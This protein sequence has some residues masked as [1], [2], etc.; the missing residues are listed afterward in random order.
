MQALAILVVALLFGGMF[1][2]S[3]GF[4]AFVF[5]ALPAALA[6]PTLRRAF[7]HFYLFVI[8]TAAVAAVLMLSLDKESALYLAIIAITT[9][10]ARQFLMP[11]INT[12]TDRQAKS[13]FKVLHGLSVLISLGHIAL[14]G[15]VLTRFA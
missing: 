10:P 15:L 4:A 8:V 12:A 5:S 3:F 13:R 1:L 14:A 2:Y 11:A 7:P 9:V 6:G